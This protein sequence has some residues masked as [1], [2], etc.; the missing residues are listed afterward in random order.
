[1]R[2][3]PLAG[4]EPEERSALLREV[5]TDCPSQ[6]RVSGFEGVEDRALRGRACDVDGYLGVDPRQ[7]P[8]VVRQDDPDYRNVCT[9]TD[10]TAGRSC[11]M[12]DQLLPASVDT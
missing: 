9:S 10:K 8:Q 4:E 12:A 6:H 1:V 3:I 2:K 5:V 11:T 7:P